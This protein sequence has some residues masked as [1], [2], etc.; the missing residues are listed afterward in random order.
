[1]AASSEK[2]KLTKRI[3][4]ANRCTRWWNCPLA[5]GTRKQRSDGNQ[6][7]DYCQKSA[8]FVVPLVGKK[9]AMSASSHVLEASIAMW[10]ILKEGDVAL[11][12]YPL[13]KK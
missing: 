1:M 8:Y 2:C 10:G 9:L 3:A 7:L 4:S 12:P 5:I 6:E 11:P 13:I